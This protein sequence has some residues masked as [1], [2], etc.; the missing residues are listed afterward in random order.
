MY[1]ALTRSCT[2]VP[3]TNTV[4]TLK[5]EACQHVF[6]LYGQQFIC[7]SAERAAKKFKAKPTI[8]I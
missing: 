7:R 8:D 6:T 5:L 1:I 3:K 2:E 4:F